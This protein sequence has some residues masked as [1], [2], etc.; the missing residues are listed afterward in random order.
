MSDIDK[1]T[2]VDNFDNKPWIEFTAPSDFYESIVNELKNNKD[3]VLKREESGKALFELQGQTLLV[4]E[5]ESG[6]VD[7]KVHNVPEKI[8][9]M[10]GEMFKKMLTSMNVNPDDLS[11]IDSDES[12]DDDDED[13]DDEDERDGL[14]S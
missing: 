14:L 13:D 12:D 2:P 7:V 6:K 1:A 5:I 8:S 10:M 4:R 3:A 9:N 11:T